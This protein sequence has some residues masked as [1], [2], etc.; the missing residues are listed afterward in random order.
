MGHCICVYVAKT[1]LS[2]KSETMQSVLRHCFRG[3]LSA[4]CRKHDALL[5]SIAF[6]EDSYWLHFRSCPFN[7][8]TCLSELSE[9]ARHYSWRCHL[10]SARSPLFCYA[11]ARCCSPSALHFTE[12]VYE[13]A[14]FENLHICCLPLSAAMRNRLGAQGIHSLS[15]CARAIKQGKLNAHTVEEHYLLDAV[16]DSFDAIYGLDDS[17]GIGDVSQ[18]VLELKRAEKT[19]AR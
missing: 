1:T 2:E 11:V 19:Y 4:L 15:A 12:H 6:D 10:V 7:I 17:P 14:V 3:E 18:S 5:E 16:R 9:L 13:I 8:D